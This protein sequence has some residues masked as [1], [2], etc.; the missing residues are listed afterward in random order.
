MDLTA[1]ARWSTLD[2]ARSN[3]MSRCEQYAAWTIP[4]LCREA[5]ITQENQELS[6]DWQDVGAMGVNSL[7]NR[8]MLALFSPSR[9]FFRYKLLPAAL[10]ELRLAGASEDD[11]VESMTAAEKQATDLLDGLSIRPKL[12]EV[13]K[14]LIAIG[15]ALMEFMDDGI[16]VYGIRRYCVQRDS[17][18]RVAEILIREDLKK[19]E[20]E[21]DV[22][23]VLT[24]QGRNNPAECVEFYRWIKRQ[25]DGDYHM[26]QWV[27]TTRLPARFNGKWPEDQLPYRVLTWDLA[28][29]DHY[30]TG[31]VE[32]EAGAF[33]ALS[34]LSESVVTAAVLSSEF[35]WLVNPAGITKAED[36][37]KSR[38][39]QA[40]PGVDSD[41]KLLNSGTGSA[42]Q[43]V[44]LIA[45]SYIDRLA[46]AFLIGGTMVRDAERV[47]AEEIRLLINELETTL[48][49]AYTRTSVDLQQPLAY[50]LTRRNGVK[51]GS[52]V[53]P[54][55]VTG[56]DALSRNG[57][58]E[59]MKLWLGDM[60]ALATLPEPLQKGLNLLKV[61]AVLA[62]G[63]GIIASQYM[64]SEDEQAT[65]TAD[66]AG[67]AVA[68][69]AA[70]AAAQSAAQGETQ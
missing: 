66:E 44:Q 34:T 70:T 42:L 27:G 54:T 1:Q 22:Q 29:E 36:F 49:G 38:N 11:L 5:G 9:P 4:K 24:S 7:A 20:L 46:R 13:L 61:A 41:I 2:S 40:L 62:A 21:E 26:E 53:R 8:M 43:P 18:G 3:F 32:E 51:L 57:D 45:Q 47:T 69:A 52:G 15:N 30:G 14:H 28:D 6:H 35:R 58:L 67:T 56:L 23:E 17:R 16:R 37:N 33:A 12:F 63:R 39:G 10:K 60:A 68:T 65:E 31:L 64:R 48:G 19:G 55:I 50:W 25:P 59:N